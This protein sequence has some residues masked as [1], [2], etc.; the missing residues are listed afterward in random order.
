MGK[1]YT[2]KINETPFFKHHVD[3][4]PLTANNDD[5]GVLVPLLY[6]QASFGDCLFA[7]INPLLK[8]YYWIFISKVEGHFERV[9]RASFLVDFNNFAVLEV[10]YHLIV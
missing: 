8:S 3:Y 5:F 1:S 10:P 9:Y 6:S 4:G 2:L 7:S